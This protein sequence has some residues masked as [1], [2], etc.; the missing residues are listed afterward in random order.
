MLHTF[1]KDFYKTI[2]F[3]KGEEWREEAFR[4]Y[5]LSDAI[6]FECKVGCYHRKTIDEFVSEF[7]SLIKFHPEY[8]EN[9]F[10]EKQVNVKIIENDISTLTSSEYEKCYCISGKEVKEYGIFNMSIVKKDG[11][12]KIAC[13]IW[14]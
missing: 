2:S 11:T 10:Q 4:E 5:F 6:L 12:L 1:I 8:F 14:S 13:L 7:T 3:D 9:G